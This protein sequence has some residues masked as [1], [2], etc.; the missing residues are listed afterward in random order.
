[1]MSPNGLASPPVYAS[2]YGLVN[3]FRG[4]AALAVV[5][6]H[7]K[8][9][10]SDNTGGTHESSHVLF[11]FGYQA[12]LVFFVISGYCIAASAQGCIQRGF[13]FH[14]F[15]WR[16]VKRI[17]PPYLLA[18]AFWACTRYIKYRVD[19][20]WALDRSAAEWLQN[21]TL[22]Q[23]LSLI[24]DPIN[25]P[26]ANPR[27]FVAAFWSLCY[28]EQFYLVMAG[29]LALVARYPK[30]VLHGIIALAIISIAW[31]AAFPTR[32][33]G[34]FIEYWAAFASGSLAYYRL[35]V[36]I[37]ARSRHA[38]DVSLLLLCLTSAYL[39]W[40]PDADWG[41]PPSTED[42]FVVSWTSVALASGMA[43]VLI[44]IRPLDDTYRSLRSVS[45]PLAGLA[46]ISYSLYLTH[47]YCLAFAGGVARRVISTL[48][49]PE[50]WELNCAGQIL[51]LLG[52]ATVFW[53]LCERPFLNTNRSAQQLRD[54]R[55]SSPH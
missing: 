53:Y 49:L 4:C 19:G 50:R 34:F 5:F 21:V 31:G 28:E 35:C 39:G 7:V 43:L 23:W 41:P 17:Y 29:L 42:A 9:G 16:R 25:N 12:V 26:A 27:L 33:F 24:W 20:E 36:L 3:A 10:S 52:V 22:T 30:A 47:Q 13:A 8:I 48:H 1:M 54:A 11:P 40:G 38:I 15:M 2:H 44:A 14:E 51:V 37:D 6:A 18:I 46:A 45:V 32:K 55:S